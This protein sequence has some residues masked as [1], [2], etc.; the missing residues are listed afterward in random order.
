MAC[1]ASLPPGAR[2]FDSLGVV[3]VK[4]YIA[5]KPLLST[6]DWP[7]R[8]SCVIFFAGCNLRC[9]LCFNGPIIALEEK[10]LVDLVCLYAELNKQRFIIE[11]VIATGGEPT[12]QLPCLRALGM[13]AHQNGLL[14]GLMTNGTRPGV[15]SNML[16]DQLLDYVAVDIKTVP[17]AEAYSRIAQ[18]EEDVL[19]PVKESV[20]LVRQSK[21]DHEFR[22]T[23]VPGLIDQPS[24]IRQISGWVGTKN[25][26]LQVFLPSEGVL[27]SEL[28]QRSFS[29]EA[30]SYLRDYAKRHGIAIRF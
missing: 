15:L 5:G 22:T 19:S 3:Q 23:L 21:I 25:Y 28:R 13:W 12:L 20:K 9:R 4:G 2:S 10:F 18:S 30:I 24:Q 1:A 14:F 8:V 16:A 27:D 7:S 26:V 6:T 17:K 11:A 29:P